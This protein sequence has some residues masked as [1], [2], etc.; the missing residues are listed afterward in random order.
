MVDST[1]L[2]RSIF[3]SDNAEVHDVPMSVIKRPIPSVLDEEKVQDF[4]GK[5]KVH[6]SSVWSQTPSSTAW[7]GTILQSEDCLVYRGPDIKAEQT[8]IQ[9]CT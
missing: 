2:P 4:A 9:W 3:V 6:M 5:I 8:A 1:G 7:L